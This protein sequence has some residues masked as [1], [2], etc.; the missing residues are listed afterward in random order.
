MGPRRGDTRAAAPDHLRDS[1]LPAE[2][3][4]DRYLPLDRDCAQAD[5]DPAHHGAGSVHS[6]A[7]QVPVLGQVQPEKGIPRALAHV[8]GRTDLHH[9]SLL[10]L[11]RVRVF[12]PLALLLGDERSEP[13]ARADRASPDHDLLPAQVLLAHS[14]ADTLRKL[15][16]VK[17]PCSSSK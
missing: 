11:I 15:P 14:L 6:E 12:E 16:K 5:P 2:A 4:P 7:R 3:A 1:L 8:S 10:E 9:A 17:T 13:A